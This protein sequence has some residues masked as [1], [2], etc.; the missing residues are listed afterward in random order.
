MIDV[1]LLGTGGMV[2]LPGRFLTA[3]YIRH[4]GRALLI[5]CGEGTQ[6]AMRASGMRFKAVDAVLFTHYH[7]DHISGLPGFLLTL[8]NEGREEPLR[9]YGPPGLQRVVEALRVIAPELPYPVELWELPREGG[10]F[11]AADMWITAFPLEHGQIPCFGYR[12]A[13]PRARRFD[14]DQ[15]RSLGIPVK[16]WGRLQ[17]GEDVGG[18]HARDVLGPVRRGLTLLYAT[19]TRPVD[20]VAEYGAEAELMVLEGMFG[21]P[22]KQQRVLDTNHMLMSEA[23][24]LAARARAR[25][26]WLTHYSPATQEPEQYL[27]ALRAVFP[28]T[29]MGIDGMRTTLRF[30]EE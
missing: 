12:C 3:L 30:I 27:E 5:D 10:V 16:L 13:L 20:A 15:A 28:G 4:E 11:Q 1:C 14:P 8:G 29:C 24:E 7:A 17:K 2:P 21:D 26:L 19:D 23:A 9:L 18:F 22:A 6:M 25:T